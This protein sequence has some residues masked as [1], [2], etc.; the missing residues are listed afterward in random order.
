MEPEFQTKLVNALLDQQRKELRWK[1]VRFFLLGG[2]FAL[3]ILAYV[4]AIGAAMGP[5]AKPDNDYVA[6][7]RINGAIGPNEKASARFV[8]PAL[9][10]A[11]NDKQAKGVVVVIN[12][13]G[14][15]PVQSSLIRDRIIKLREEFPDKKVVVVAEDMLTSGAYM[16]ATGVDTIYVN[17]STLTGSIGVIIRSFGFVELADKLGV[18]RRVYTAGENKNSMDPF[19]PV[20][21]QDKEKLKATL[22]QVHQHFIDAVMESRGDKLKESPDELFTGEF[23][24]GEQAVEL[25]L[26]DGISDLASVIRDDFDVKHIVE[27]GEEKALLAR[28]TKLLGSSMADA[29]WQKMESSTHQD[30]VMWH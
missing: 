18:E 17:R 8:I 9:I 12:S 24:T 21:E 23:W 7:V 16:I 10:E 13:P 14:G 29:V 5:G 28:L 30:S 1:K 25:G 22:T 3:I 27:Y 11:F 6:L 4:A 19:T 2:F 15:T 20:D 26:V